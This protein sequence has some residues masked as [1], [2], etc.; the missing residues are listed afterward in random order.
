MTRQEMFNLIVKKKWNNEILGK[1]GHPYSSC[2]NS[3]LA[4]FIEEKQTG[5]SMQENGE[6][7][8]KEKQEKQKPKTQDEILQEILARVDSYKASTEELRNNTDKLDSYTKL[9]EKV[10]RCKSFIITCSE[11]YGEGDVIKKDNTEMVFDDSEFVRELLICF[12]TERINS[13]MDSI[14]KTQNKMKAV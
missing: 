9:L 12:I 10:K 5:S 11:S 1:Y 13:L 7:V 14:E 8:K 4:A 2:S 3:T 6:L